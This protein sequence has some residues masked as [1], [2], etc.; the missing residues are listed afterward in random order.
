VSVAMPEIAYEWRGI[1]ITF[2]QFLL[3]F[4]M[5]EAWNEGRAAFDLFTR[6]VLGIL[7]AGFAA[8][9]VG[10]RA[11][12]ADFRRVLEFGIL[13]S[14]LLSP[15]LEGHHYAWALPA[16]LLQIGR[17]SRGELGWRTA[18]V[19]AAGWFMI[20]LDLF[21][22]NYT[23]NLGAVWKFMPMFGGLVLVGAAGMELAPRPERAYLSRT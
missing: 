14:P 7:A 13:Y 11:R 15:L 12:G 6:V 19:Y 4:W 17:W 21:Y 1:S 9:V 2:G 18:W 16:L 8:G 10:Y 3:K 23:H 5:P 20:S 22:I